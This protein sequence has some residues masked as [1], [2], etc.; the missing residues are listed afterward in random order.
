MYSASTRSAPPYPPTLAAS[1]KNKA[2]ENGDDKNPYFKIK[3]NIDV[4]L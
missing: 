1:T 2:Y 3:N 4:E